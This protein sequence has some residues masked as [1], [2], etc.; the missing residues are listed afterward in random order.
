MQQVPNKKIRCCKQ[1]TRLN[2]YHNCLIENDIV[3]IQMLHIWFDQ[4]YD[5][6]PTRL[7]FYDGKYKTYYTDLNIIKIVDDI[8]LNKTYDSDGSYLLYYED[9]Y[10][11]NFKN[12]IRNTKTLKS[13]VG[14]YIIDWKNNKKLISDLIANKSEYIELNY[15]IYF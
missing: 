14:K 8:K 6:V 4:I 1:I 7:E 9:P 12:L 3:E 5:I 13:L 10:V 15:Y 11:K 2:K